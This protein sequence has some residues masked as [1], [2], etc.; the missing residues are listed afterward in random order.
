MEIPLLIVLI[1]RF[2]CNE[3]TDARTSEYS[4]Q[5]TLD[6]AASK[7]KKGLRF[8]EK[9]ARRISRHI[10]DFRLMFQLV[11]AAYLRRTSSDVNEGIFFR[12]FCRKLIVASTAEYK[13]EGS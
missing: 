4:A 12:G 3:N 13:R 8:P 11:F 5:F 2:I 7:W 1:F 6:L 9:F 10:S